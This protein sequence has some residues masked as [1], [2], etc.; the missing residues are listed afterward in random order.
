VEPVVT[1]GRQEL[2]VIGE[3]SYQQAQPSQVERRIIVGHGGRQDVSG[4]RR[5]QLP[6]GHDNDEAQFRVE[7]KQPGDR[8]PLDNRRGHQAAQRRRCR[9][10]G[11]PVN[12]KT[13]LERVDGARCRRRSY[14]NG[15]RRPKPSGDGD[16]GAHVHFQ[17][18]MAR[19]PARNL[20]R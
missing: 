19:Y 3:A 16:L 20:C 4:S 6:V 9:V 7:A 13:S 15:C 14:R 11:V 1:R 10:F 12:N 8:A 18:V 2:A 5:R 17:P